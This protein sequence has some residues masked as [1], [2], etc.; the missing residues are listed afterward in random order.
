MSQIYLSRCQTGHCLHFQL[1]HTLRQLESLCHTSNMEMKLTSSCST[2]YPCSIF[3]FAG[4]A[5]SHARGKSSATLVRRSSPPGYWRLRSSNP[6]INCRPQ[7]HLK[8]ATLSALCNNLPYFFF[9]Q[10][11]RDDGCHGSCGHHL[12]LPLLNIKSDVAI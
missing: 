11:T 9:W 6:G 8:Y 1:L 5:S 2:N 7:C 10:Q 4:V 12:M 3:V